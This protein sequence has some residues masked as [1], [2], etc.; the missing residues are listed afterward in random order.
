MRVLYFSEEQEDHIK[1]M[2]VTNDDSYIPY[3]F[4]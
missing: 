4:I 1:V 2:N 3:L